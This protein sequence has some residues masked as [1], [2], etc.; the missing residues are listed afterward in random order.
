M[1]KPPPTPE[2][3][4]FATT[5]DYGDD[6]RWAARA[7]LIAPPN[8]LLD[9]LRVLVQVLRAA[10]R[11][12]ALLLDSSSG[13]IHPDVLAAVLIGLFSRRR[14]PAIVLM[15]CMWQRDPGLRGLV[16]GLIV[17]LADRAI[18]RYAVQSSKELDIFPRTWKVAGGR[19]RFCPYFFTLTVPDLE[20]D[21]PRQGDYIFAGG[22]SHRDYE[23]LVAAAH[24]LP[25][26]RFIIATSRLKHHRD[27]PPNV[28]AGPTSHAEFMSLL[29][30]AAAVVV[31]MRAGLTR[32]AGQQTYLNA[33]WL[34]KLAV[35][36]D[37]PAARDHIEDGATGLIVD[38]S[39]QSYVRALRWA[40]DPAHRDDVERLRR[41]GQ[42]AARERFTFE[43]H[44]TC[45]LAVLDEAAA[46]AGEMGQGY[47]TRSR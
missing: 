9:E 33:M 29:R 14:R 45:L 28:V 15:G 24:R 46:A 30:G 5:V 34:G 3:I 32:A 35:V 18:D 22:D 41:A 37:T 17:R 16:E 19:M 7:R 6:P 8:G 38:G 11:E 10:R 20:A 2:P 12:R 1:T 21:P 43:N 36:T 42:Q 23:P 25:Q 26:H 31:P 13:C 39:P 47:N 27:L 44:V 40:L 4:R